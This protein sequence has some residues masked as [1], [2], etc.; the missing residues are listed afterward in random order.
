[1]QGL[2]VQIQQRRPVSIRAALHCDRGELLA[3]VGPSGSGKSTVLRCIAGLHKADQSAIQCAGEIW[4]NP[5]SGHRLR[6]QQRKVGMVF[7]EYA[8]FP[9]KSALDNVMLAT[10]GAN[11]KERRYKAMTLLERT[12]MTGLEDRMPHAL[13]GGQKQR[14]ALARALA[15]EP[16]VLLLDEPFSAVDQQT[17]RKLYSELAALRQSLEL[18]IILVTHD[19]TEVQLLADT[20]CLMHRG[21]SLHQGAV[22]DVINH[23]NS[24][25]VARLVGH[26]NLFNAV[27]VGQQDAQTQYQLGDIAAFAGPKLESARVGDQASLLISPSAIQLSTSDTTA[28]PSAHDAADYV[29]ALDGTVQE[30]VLLGDEVFI[31]LHLENVPKSLRFKL[32]MHVASCEGIRQGSMLR[33]NVQHHGIHAMAN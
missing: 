25:E 2:D 16:R 7:Q 26:Q 3:L 1:M 33:V 24:R 15:R 31:R 10:P 27:V 6:P 30:S 32:P 5:D 14:V 13:S 23:P 12:N 4:D 29:F 21:V 28:H 22:A 8:L 20:L 17:R 11:R 19:L 9:H 18:P